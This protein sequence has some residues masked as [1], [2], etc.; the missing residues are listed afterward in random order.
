MDWWYRTLAAF[1]AGA[2]TATGIDSLTPWHVDAV[3]VVLAWLLG[4]FAVEHALGVDLARVERATGE[5]AFVSL[6]VSLGFLASLASSAGSPGT[7]SW[8]RTTLLF[9]VGGVLVCYAVDYTHY[10]TR[11][12]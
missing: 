6:G 3:A 8:D 9:A 12:Q 2:V 5:I 11:R 4:L 1:L 10:R 7:T